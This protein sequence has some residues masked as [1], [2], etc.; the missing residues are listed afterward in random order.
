MNWECSGVDGF[1]TKV[2]SC[3]VNYNDGLLK[4]EG[5]CDAQKNYHLIKLP[6]LIEYVGYCLCCGTH[7]AGPVYEMKEYLDWAEGKGQK[8]HLLHLMGQPSR[9]RCIDCKEKMDFDLYGDCYTT[10][11][12]LPGRFSQQHTSEHEFKSFKMIDTNNSGTITFEELKEGLRSVGSN[13]MESKIKSLMEAVDYA[14][15]AAMMKKGDDDVGRS[16]TMK[17]NLNFNIA[18]AF[19]VNESS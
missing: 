15:F 2:I 5:L 4:E 8:D 7:F 6:S 14:E 1:D 11:S 13:L 18:D 3:A 10:R 19:G 9:Y 17:G 12:K 16:R